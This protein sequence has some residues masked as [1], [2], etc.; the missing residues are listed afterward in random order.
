MLTALNEL[1]KENCLDVLRKEVALR[2][3][4]CGSLYWNVA[5]DDCQKIADC[6]IFKF[7]CDYATVQKILNG[8]VE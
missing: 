8:E 1:T 3:K 4:M 7:K 5:N 6:C 2:D